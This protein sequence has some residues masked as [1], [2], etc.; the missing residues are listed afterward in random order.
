MKKTLLLVA[1]AFS[2]TAF[3]DPEIFDM[4]LG[5]TTESQLKSLYNVSQTGTNKY[6]HG[7]MY[8]IPTSAID[9][10]G[11]KKITTIFD[12][13]KTLVSVI[14]ELPK[15]KF[16]YLHKLLNKKY[17]KTSQK[18]P[19]V[20]K[21]SAEYSDGNTII[22]LEAPHMSFQMSMSYSRSE[23]VESFKNISNIE[24]RQKEQNE[25]SKL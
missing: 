14:T 7:N 4:E 3:A 10:E 23:F 1:L 21:K 19:Y 25:S 2:S 12:E 24:K 5:K 6:S 17:K 22:S 16:D 8:S 13:N 18:I 15:S 11:L 9:F 20:G